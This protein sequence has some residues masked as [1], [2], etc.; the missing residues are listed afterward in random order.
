MECEEVVFSNDYY[1]FIIEYSLVNI[2]EPLTRCVQQVNAMFDIAY[3]P[4]KGSPPL[5]IENYSYTAI[6][7]CFSLLD[8]SALEASGILKI[9]NFPSL[10]LKGQGVLIGFVDTGIDY[11]NQVFLNTDGTSRIAAIWDQTD[12]SGIP[13]A[14][15]LYGSEYRNEEINSALKFPIP[16]SVVPVTDEEGHGTYIASVAAGSGIAEADFIGAA[17]YSQIAV[18]KLK[19]AK[20]YLR[21]FYFIPKDAVAF[22]ENDIMTGIA[23]LDALANE[24]RMPLVL[25]FCLGSN[26][27]SHGSAIA[28]LDK[29][30]NSLGVK[31]RRAVVVAAGNEANQRHHFYGQ[32][33][34]DQS[35]QNVEINVGSGV[36]GFVI[37][38]WARAPELFAVEII[39]PTGERVPKEFI[40]SGGG[41][42]RF[43]FEDTKVSIDYRVAGI[44]SGDQLVF[45][46]FTD[47]SQGI[48]NIRVYRQSILE[49]VYH[50]WLPMSE[51]VSG[52]VYFI[53][54]NP[55]VT[56]TVPANANIPMTV[57][58]YNVKDNSIYLESS[59]GYTTNGFVKPD[60][61]APGVEVYGAAPKNRFITRSGTSSA[62]AITAG[63][64]ALLMEWAVVQGN[65][66]A[67]SNTDMKNMLIR[68]TDRDPNRVYP[69]RE[70]GYGRLDLYQTF[71]TFRIK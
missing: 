38:M 30:L 71:E 64:V 45:M 49:G 70:W 53:R 62:A 57:G 19:Q 32:I 3:A 61:V 25:C 60:F 2:G 11:E 5:T 35:Y 51:M 55:D 54:S 37:E 33:P 23:Y 44:V 21:E 68:G 63:A 27:G 24:L 12:R 16:K 28:P 40:L 41:E 69:S 42:Y 14:G 46:R 52:E 17:P 39:S 6:P 9:Q 67:I 22:Q 7:N 36:E 20:Q 8:T 13:P 34:L 18:V 31:Q 29:M 26:M 10:S 15:F 56:I 43:I 65:Y 58:A 4:R 66:T 50:M 47:P 48:W 59:R 1:D